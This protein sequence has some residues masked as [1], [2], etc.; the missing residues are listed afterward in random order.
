MSIP[1]IDSDLAKRIVATRSDVGRFTSAD[2]LEVTLH[3]PPALLE[4]AHDL[5]IF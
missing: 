4:P 5:M 2:D 1:G 3:L